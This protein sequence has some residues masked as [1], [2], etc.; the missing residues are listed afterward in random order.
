MSLNVPTKTDIKRCTCVCIGQI[1]PLNMETSF[2]FYKQKVGSE[3]N[4][5]NVSEKRRHASVFNST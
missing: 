2:I 4:I 3:M 5:P 1:G